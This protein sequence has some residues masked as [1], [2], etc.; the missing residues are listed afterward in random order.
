MR[1]DF[2]FDFISPYAY[3]AWKRLATLRADKDVEVVIHP[4]LFAGILRRWGQL[5]PAEIPPK[6][7]FTFRDVFRF[8]ARHQIPISFPAAHPFNP[9]TALRLALPVVAGDH[10]IAIIDALFALG[11]EHGKDIGSESDIQSALEGIGLD[12]AALID[13]TRATAAKDALRAETEQAI[14]KG[15][16]GVPSYIVEK[17]VFWGN[18]RLDDAL[19]KLRGKDP[20]DWTKLQPTLDRL[21]VGAA[22]KR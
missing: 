11:W 5:G 15:I 2:Y 22:R 21:P 13:K 18:D 4:I 9:I 16:F 1:L 6:R 8:A 17:E 14:D 12:G 19:E 10:Q 20:L 3:L 7:D